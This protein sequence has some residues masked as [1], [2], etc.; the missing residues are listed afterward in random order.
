MPTLVE[1]DS[2]QHRILRIN[3]GS[4]YST[5]TD[6]GSTLPCHNGSAITFDTTVTRTADHVNSMKLANSASVGVDFR[7]TP[8][9]P[10]NL[11]VGSFYFRTT[12]TT[13]PGGDVVLILLA[14]TNNVTIR[15]QSNGTI[16]LSQ[17]SGT[18]PNTVGDYADGNWHLVDFRCDFSTTSGVCDMT[19][20]GA[21][22]IQSTGTVTVANFSTYRFGSSAAS[23]AYN[24]WY[25]D[26]I[27][28]NTSGDYPLGEHDCLK[29]NI[30]ATG[31]HSPSTGA[32][33]D[34]AGG[35]SDAA[36]L[37]SVNKAWDNTTPG[38]TQTGETFIQQTANATAGYVEYTCADVTGTIWGASLSTLMAAEDATTACTGET[39]VVDSGNTTRA[40]TGLVDP[41]VSATSYTGYRK[42][43]T[44]A[45]NGTWS[46]TNLNGCKIRFGFSGDAAPDVLWNAAIIEYARAGGAAPTEIT[47]VVLTTTPSLPAGALNQV[48]SIPD[49]NMART[50]V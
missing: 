30:D 46:D 43:F 19:V 35:T 22:A 41:S 8:Q 4:W 26:F 48:T 50:R 33:T 12:D 6:A 5:V 38:L 9:T 24:I 31:T 42:C 37:D 39:R 16:E 47:G 1:I 29:T 13:N 14:N 44:S 7:R 18:A 21:D 45:P 15:M 36:L 10:S 11:I 2:F 20:D 17:G 49:L 40:T 28:S 25:S 32:F 23:Q 27:V 34:E 3:E